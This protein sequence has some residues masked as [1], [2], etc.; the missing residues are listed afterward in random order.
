MSEYTPTDLS[1]F[2]WSIADS[3]RGA[4]KQ[5]EYGRIIL[6]F[7][8]LRRLE[9]VLEPHRE[10][11]RKIIKQTEGKP[12]RMRHAMLTDAIGQDFYN[13]TGF[14][15]KTLGADN[16]RDN[17][18]DYIHGF[19]DNVQA[20]FSHFNFNTWL[21][22]L[23]K[24]GLLLTVI[25]A[26]SS[27]DLDL[28]PDKV[29][30]QDMGTVFE[31]LIRK[32]AEASNETAG[33]HFTP[34]DVVRLTTQLVMQPDEDA[35]SGD[36]VIRSV[37]DGTAGSGGFLSSAFEMAREMNPNIDFSLYG[38]ELNAESYAIGLADMLLLGQK[39]DRY[40]LGNTLSDDQFPGERFNYGLTN[41][42]FGVNWGSSKDVERAVRAEAER[43]F[44][45]RFGAG[46]PTIRDGSMLFLQNM[47][48]KMQTPELGGGRIG[49]ILSGSPLFNGGAGSGESEI[50]RHILE[51]D[52]LEAIIALPT[53]LFHNTGIGT[54]IWVLS[55]R[56]EE[57]RR[58]KVQLIDATALD[59]PMR[60]SV[61]DKRSLIN[62]DDIRKILDVHA[63]F[64]EQDDSPKSKIF[65]TT[66]FG[67]RRISVLRPLQ[68]S[69]DITAQALDNYAAIRNPRFL[70]ELRTLEGQTFNSLP[71][72]MEAAGIPKL[73]KGVRNQIIR[74]LGQHDESAPIIWENEKKRIAEP[75]T[76]LS[77]TENV[78]LSEDVHAY[79]E[80]EVRPHVP[81]AWIDLAK[82]DHQDNK[83]GEVGY[84]INFN[85][86]FYEYQAPRSLEDIDDELRELE[87]EIAELMSEVI[88]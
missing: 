64:I 13:T 84:E 68:V 88:R 47:I 36:G 70:D 69:F 38:Q 23:N 85:R 60:K 76:S 27:D 41:P 8:V 53:N 28:S 77:E 56:K 29:S 30:N 7:A 17:I 79:F 54:Y 61:G 39:T 42:P 20:I 63:A 15:L 31:H 37:Y 14:S 46:V 34:R 43:G 62:D 3:L 67:Y 52:L 33:E 66:D 78:P 74:H 25:S 87:A 44:A 1:S 9:C 73:T 19:S 6:P 57:R 80:R 26:F 58:G 45:G 21:D 35:L 83:L 72:L 48:A 24:K 49:I 10:T 5:S 55:N 11:I 81:D 4:Y 18:A 65:N 86:Y 12:A 16:V 71:A 22:D 82:T 40:K 2:I 51:K 75:D 50:R 59:S 32:F